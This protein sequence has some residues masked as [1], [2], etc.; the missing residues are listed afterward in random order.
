MVAGFGMENYFDDFDTIDFTFL[1]CAG[2]ETLW[3]SNIDGGFMYGNGKSTGVG[4]GA[5]EFVQ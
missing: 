1:W 2:R 3:E 4:V 5:I